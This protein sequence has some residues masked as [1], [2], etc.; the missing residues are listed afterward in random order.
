MRLDISSV[1]YFDQRGKIRAVAAD[2]ED[3]LAAVAVERLDDDFAMLR[4]ECA[5]VVERA[6]D[7]RRRHEVCIIEHEQLFGRIANACRIVRHQ[8]F[9]ANALE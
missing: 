5:G 7:H 2:L 8:S 4:Q 9:A 3:R 1:E 6:R